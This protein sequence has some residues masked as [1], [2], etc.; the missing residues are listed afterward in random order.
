MIGGRHG[1]N[2]FN[3]IRVIRLSVSLADSVSGVGG[4]DF[5]TVILKVRNVGGDGAIRGVGSGCG[6][7]SEAPKVVCTLLVGI[8]RV[9]AVSGVT[10]ILLNHRISEEKRYVI[11]SYLGRQRPAGM[12]Q[13]RRL[14]TMFL[15]ENRTLAWDN[16]TGGGIWPKPGCWFRSGIRRSGDSGFGIEA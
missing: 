6:I 3:A 11:P 12:S 15:H 2:L 8:L 4:R 5:V 14:T 16:R 1:L 10:R 9:A 13:G 7:R